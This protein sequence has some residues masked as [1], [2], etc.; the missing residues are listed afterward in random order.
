MVF[1]VPDQGGTA[2][3]GGPEDVYAVKADG[4][5]VR[6]YGTSSNKAVMLPATRGDADYLA[7]KT[8]WRNGGCQDHE[9]VRAFRTANSSTYEIKSPDADSAWAVL[10]LRWS[11]SRA[12]PGS[13]WVLYSVQM[14]TRLDGQRCREGGRQLWRSMPDGVWEQVPAPPD[15]VEGVASASG[16]LAVRTGQYGAAEGTVSFIRN[17]VREP[18]AEGVVEMAWSK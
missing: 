7:W 4:T 12:R 17:D 13:Q 1:A 14:P 2:A 8:G 11:R 5:V 6:M 3:Y 10:S 9:Y 18:V 15:V 16:V